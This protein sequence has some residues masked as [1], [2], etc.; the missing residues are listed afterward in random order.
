MVGLGIGVGL[1]QIDRLFFVIGD[2]A[3]RRLRRFVEDRIAL[4][5]RVATV[6]RRLH[7]GRVG[8]GLD[9]GDLVRA[10]EVV[11]A[12]EDDADAAHADENHRRSHVNEPARTDRFA[13]GGGHRSR[14]GHRPSRPHL[15]AHIEPILIVVI[16]GFGLI[17]LPVIQ[18][19]IIRLVLVVPLGLLRLLAA[20][21]GL[22]IRLSAVVGL[23]V[24]EQP[25]L[26]LVI[27]RLATV[28]FWIR[29]CCPP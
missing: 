3:R 12:G 20:V 29:S 28:Q 15:M 23:A 2:P 1:R 24:R 26:G 14:R 8:R 25:R 16:G 18:I 13:H 7:L 6:V 10:S 21:I 11:L 17:L 4:H 27:D 22:I 9:H 19:A 5:R